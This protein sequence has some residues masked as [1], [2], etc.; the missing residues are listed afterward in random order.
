MKSTP[1]LLRLQEPLSG[2]FMRPFLPTRALFHGYRS[3]LTILVP[4]ATKS[5]T[6]FSV[7]QRPN[8]ICSAKW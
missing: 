1:S 5:Y 3:L 8:P 7:R 6:S 4:L 2:M